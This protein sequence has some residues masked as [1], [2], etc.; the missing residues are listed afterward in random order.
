MK[1][2][3]LRASFE[4]TAAY[5][6]ITGSR[7]LD[8]WQLAKKI[9][10]FCKIMPLSQKKDI[11]NL[12]PE[13]LKQEFAAMGEPAFRARQV[14]EWLWVK[15]CT[16]FDEMSNLSKP[17]REKL[18]ELFTI[19]NVTVNQ[20][21]YSFDK[22][23]KSTFRL[24]D[25]NIIEGVLIPATDRMTACVSSQVGCSL[26]CKFC[27]TG[28]MERKRNLNADE[29]YDQVVLIDQQA[30]ENY[31]VPLTNIV[32][33]GMGE[34]LLNYANVMKSV[35]R[36]TAPDGLNMAAKRITVS[37]A[38]IA[39]MIRKLGDDA[40]RFNLALSLHAANDEKRN[41]IMP[42]NEQNSLKALA[43]ALKYYFSKTKNPVTYEYIVFDKFN[44]AIE[45]AAELVKFC[46]HIP[47]KVNIIEYNPISFADFENANEDR[48]E[49]FAAHLRKN[50]I[51]TNIRRSRG[52]DIDAAC[53]QLAVKS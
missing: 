29:I 14:Y 32:Y 17:L 49:A 27:A 41:T 26:T 13:Q 37:T 43:E 11:R 2:I 47:C 42:V 38:G 22:T 6:H 3:S 39:K 15:S 48:I 50:G 21:Q 23:I 46:R 36:I 45:D 52:K 8:N 16:D 9:S 5:E 44:D 51:N 12:S 40:V 7:R 19:N 20:S 30:K 35:E 10:Y 34:P 33:M 31:N 4:M 53:G 18:K 1:Q 28:Y 24:F 25:G